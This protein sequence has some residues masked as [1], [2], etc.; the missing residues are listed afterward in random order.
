MMS[1]QNEIHLNLKKKGNPAICDN[2]GGLED[3][4]ERYYK[5]LT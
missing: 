3:T 5:A 4:V 2:M 1:T